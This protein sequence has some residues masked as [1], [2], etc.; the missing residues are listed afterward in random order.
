M[1]RRLAFEPVIER[2]L[3]DSRRGKI[4]SNKEMGRRIRNIA[5]MGWTGLH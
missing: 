3:D 4:I 5:E 1:K 2:G